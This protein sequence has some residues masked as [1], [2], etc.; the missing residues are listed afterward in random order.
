M[1][2]K[3]SI[4]QYTFTSCM[5]KPTAMH[6]RQ[7]VSMQ[8][9]FP[10]EGI[11][12]AELSPESTNALEKMGPSDMKNDQVD[13]KTLAPDVEEHV[14]ERVDVNPG[15]STRRV[16]MQEGIS[17]SSVCKSYITSYC[18]HTISNTLKVS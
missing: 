7:R 13:K 2:E 9:L 1:E 10:T 14:L 5:A 3:Y 16:A 11:P 6:S 15:T 8:K 12:T 4:V 17:A 18:T